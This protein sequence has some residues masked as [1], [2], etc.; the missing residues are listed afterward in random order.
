MINA[1]QWFELD[2]AETPL[3]NSIEINGRL[4]FKDSASL[5][6]VKLRAKQIFVRA[7]NLRIGLANAPF[8]NT[9]LIELG[10]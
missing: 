2:I 3:L 1:T 8:S 9:G 10:G 5:P 6:I 7:G 4:S